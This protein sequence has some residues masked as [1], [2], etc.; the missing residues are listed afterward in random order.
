MRLA[1]ILSFLLGPAL[2]CKP[3]NS[4][5]TAKASSKNKAVGLEE[6]IGRCDMRKKKNSCFEY[7]VLADDVKPADLAKMCGSTWMYKDACP[8]K[9]VVG[10]CEV[11]ADG[12]KM[13]VFYYADAEKGREICDE[14]GGA[15]SK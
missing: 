15:W 13:L 8:Q 2:A 12:S 1:F 5:A 10:H 9:G 6:A 7:R 11:E 3:A 14:K 4:G